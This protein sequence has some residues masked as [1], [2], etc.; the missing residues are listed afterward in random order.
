[1]RDSVRCPTRDDASNPLFL[2]VISRNSCLD[3]Q[4]RFYHKCA[5]CSHRVGIP[6][7]PVVLGEAGRNGNGNGI[8]AH[9]SS[10]NGRAT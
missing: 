5:N 9:G 10:R 3:L 2:H 6:F 1:M 4:S 8:A 7:Y